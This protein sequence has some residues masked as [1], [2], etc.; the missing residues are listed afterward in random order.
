MADNCTTCG[1]TLPAGHVAP[2]KAAFIKIGAE[3]K[4]S[5]ICQQV[6]RMPTATQQNKDALESLPTTVARYKQLTIGQWKMFCAIHKAVTG[7]W[8]PDKKEF[9]VE[10]RE[11]DRGPL[12]DD[13]DLI[14]F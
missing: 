3:R 13:E 6:A 4:F 9:E 8:P 1:Q 10:E 14:P 2:Q 7:T 12:P 5:N 11:P